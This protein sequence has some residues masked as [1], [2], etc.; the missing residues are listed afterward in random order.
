MQAKAFSEEACRALQAQTG[1]LFACLVKKF[2]SANCDNN[3]FD[4]TSKRY[5]YVPALLKDLSKPDRVR[6]LYGLFECELPEFVTIKGQCIRVLLPRNHELVQKRARSQKSFDILFGGLDGW[7]L[8][9][10]KYGAA[11]GNQMALEQLAVDWL[12]GNW[13]PNFHNEC[14]R[15]LGFERQLAAVTMDECGMGPSTEDM[16]H[17][18]GYEQLKAQYAPEG[19]N[20]EAMDELM[21]AFLS[22]DDARYQQLRRQFESK[23][24]KG[25]FAVV[26]LVSVVAF[27]SYWLL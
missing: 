4:H 12:D 24:R 3:A 1:E 7:E 10:T 15:V 16:L 20:P 13:G 21:R 17:L 25:C 19:G 8:H 26:L 9:L 5:S 2:I 14:R 27:A 23:G 22:G 6:L 18:A 11:G